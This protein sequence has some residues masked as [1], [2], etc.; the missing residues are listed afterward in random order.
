MA[1]K[2]SKKLNETLSEKDRNAVESLFNVSE[3]LEQFFSY[4]E[5]SGEERETIADKQLN[6]MYLVEQ[7]VK[8]KDMHIANTEKKSRIHDLL[9]DTDISYLIEEVKTEM[10]SVQK[11]MVARAKAISLDLQKEFGTVEKSFNSLIDS[12]IENEIEKGKDA[13]DKK[14]KILEEEKEKSGKS[15]IKYEGKGFWANFKKIRE[16]G[17]EDPTQKKGIIKSLVEAYKTTI[18]ES[19]PQVDEQPKDAE[20]E[21]LEKEME[22]L[23]EQIKTSKENTKRLQEQKKDVRKQL[24][25]ANERAMEEAKDILEESIQFIPEKEITEERVGGVFERIAA[26]RHNKK[27]ERLKGKIHG[28]T[29]DINGMSAEMKDRKERLEK[30]GENKEYRKDI[31]FDVKNI[32][33][34]QVQRYNLAKKVHKEEILHAAKQNIREAKER[35]RNE[36]MDR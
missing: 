25:A 21:K 29:A 32:T 36:G 7:I 10:A 28:L 35:N 9:K 33:K 5:C 6:I 19:K 23:E 15:L 3:K 22:A 13:E 18:E 27:V 34:K 14:K 8:I 11:H 31:D 2:L 26:Y 1:E 12:N 30:E 17:K 4:S 16:Q 24:I 20:V